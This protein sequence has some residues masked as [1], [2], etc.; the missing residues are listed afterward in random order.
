M[1]VDSPLPTRVPCP[2]G[3]GSA[4]CSRTFS[5]PHGHPSPGSGQSPR[6]SPS[7][8]PWIPS[9]RGAS[10][11]HSYLGH[12]EAVGELMQDAHGLGVRGTHFH[13]RLPGL[14]GPRLCWLQG[15]GLSASWGRPAPRVAARSSFLEPRVSPRDAQVGPRPRGVRSGCAWWLSERR[16]LGDTQA[17]VLRGAQ[18][19]REMWRSFG[20]HVQQ[21]RGRD[22][23]PH[24]LMTV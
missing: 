15:A 14:Q 20:T 23:R 7:S 11:L 21:G 8:P 22:H 5:G 24:W 18:P 4:R 10:S 2:R 6:P 12:H 9:P 17:G 1:G 13:P 16:G 19:P 3:Q